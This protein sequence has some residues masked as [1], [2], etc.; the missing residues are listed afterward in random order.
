MITCFFLG[1][2]VVDDLIVVLLS[3]H[4]FIAGLIAFILDNSM[5]GKL[6]LYLF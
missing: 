1:S 3:T 5:P 6:K 4:M 2:A